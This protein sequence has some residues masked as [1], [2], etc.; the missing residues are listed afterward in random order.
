[1]TRS[2]LDSSIEMEF[3]VS[4]ESPY[5]SHYACKILRAQM[6]PVKVISENVGE[7]SEIV[8]TTI[9]ELLLRFRL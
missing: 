5:F 4:D 2:H 3:L 8:V 1:M 7:S 9:F 6:L